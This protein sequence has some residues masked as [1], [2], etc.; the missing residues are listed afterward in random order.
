LTKPSLM[1]TYQP[2]RM[3]STN[4][5]SELPETKRRLLD[6]G[7]SLMRQQGYNATTVDDI[8][9]AAGVTKGGFFHYFKSKEEVAKAAVERFR[10]VKTQ[11]FQDAPFR[12]LVD[13]LARVYGR[14]DFAKE[15]TGDGKHLTKG[16]LMG[17]FAQELSF[18]HPELRSV[19]Q[20]SFTR[21][22]GDFE[23]DLAEAKSLHSPKANFDP[24]NVAMLYV[25][26]IQ[27]SLMLAKAAE[28]NA[29]LHEN[30]EQ[31]RRYLQGLFGQSSGK[32]RD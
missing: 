32:S 21:M 7:V 18:T 28:T 20:E 19:C 25:T 9:H 6:A 4:Q 17:V 16:C 1:A 31:F 15:S 3:T 8:C 5:I 29:V 11:S 10:E 13:P 27:G 30:I 24:K 14:L 12:Q 22:A 26:I 23:K 2:V